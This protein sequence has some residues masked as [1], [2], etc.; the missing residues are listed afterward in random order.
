MDCLID[1]LLLY[2]RDL[3]LE[4]A[5]FHFRLLGGTANGIISGRSGFFPSFLRFSV[6]VF[7]V[8]L[9]RRLETV[10]RNGRIE[11]VALT[12]KTIVTVDLG[13]R[14]QT[15]WTMLVNDALMVNAIALWVD[16]FLCARPDLGDDWLVR[17]TLD[18]VMNLEI[19][20]TAIC[21][22]K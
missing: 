17:R 11:L 14:N 13:Y 3:D 10:E 4:V 9:H 20:L 2:F 16:V 7:V 12:D 1:A 6:E 19:L 8:A 15:V 22:E 5:N 18:P 21:D